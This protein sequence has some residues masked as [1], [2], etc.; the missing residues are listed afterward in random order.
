MR[1]F[2]N[3]TD[4]EIATDIAN[5]LN[6]TPRIPP[7][8]SS[9]E[10]RYAHLLMK[11]EPPILFLM[12]RARRLGYDIYVTIPEDGDEPELF[13]G[14]TPTSQTTYEL[15][16]GRSLIQFTP[17]LKVRGQVGKVVV[18][19]WN[20]T[21]SGNDRAITGEATWSDL[22]PDMPDQQ[23]L[24]S[25]DSSLAETYE[26]DIDHP[27]SSREEA[28]QEARGVLENLIKSLVTGS[29]STVGLPDLR[30]GK[31]IVITGLGLRY[32]GRYVITETTHK[33]GGS[34]YTTDFSARMEVLP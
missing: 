31:T 5:E 8:Q 29:G 2:E 27:I 9:E 30:A 22:G 11:N 7:G 17:T 13:F 23:L 15:T 16:W 32:S 1:V 6:I 26:T 4:S 12:R 33:I 24:S 20:P 3:K 14:R 28:N 34:G 19:G 18:R 10:T 25:I 21:A